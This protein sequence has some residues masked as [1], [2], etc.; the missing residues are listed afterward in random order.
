M[1]I[2]TAIMSS[3]EREKRNFLNWDH[4]INPTSEGDFLLNLLSYAQRFSSRKVRG[5]IENGILTIEYLKSATFRRGSSFGDSID[6]HWTCGLCFSMHTCREIYG[7]AS[8]FG[9]WSAN[10]LA[11]W[12]KVTK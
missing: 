10:F 5:K 9:L 8:H 6:P 12:K 1:N 11:Q 7:R 4:D 3:K 2:V